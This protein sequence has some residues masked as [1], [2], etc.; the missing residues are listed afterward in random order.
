MSEKQ[1]AR[2]RRKEDGM[3]NSKMMKKKVRLKLKERQRKFIFNHVS[4][5]KQSQ[6]ESLDL[7]YLHKKINTQSSIDKEV[8]WFTLA[9]RQ[10]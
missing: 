1:R 10:H 7:S 4:V 6:V 2:K 9:P 8:L 3:K 5:L